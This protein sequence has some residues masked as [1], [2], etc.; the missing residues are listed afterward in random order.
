MFDRVCESNEDFKK[1]AKEDD[2]KNKISKIAEV[3][4]ASININAFSDSKRITI[5]GITGTREQYFIYDLL[6][7]IN[8][9]CVPNLNTLML[10]DG[11]MTCKALKNI[12][13]GDQ[14]FIS[15]LGETHNME[16]VERQE[17]IKKVWFFECHCSLCTSQK[18]K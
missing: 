3:H 18:A 8:H 17:K 13:K 14:L 11:V 10:T 9:S 7:R 16:L 5:D 12:D 2:F 6:C 15:Y 1:R 4:L